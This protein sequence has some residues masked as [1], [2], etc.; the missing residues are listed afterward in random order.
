MT[1]SLCD[2][3]IWKDGKVARGII[4]RCG[5]LVGHG[6][7]HV[8]VE[9]LDEAGGDIPPTIDEEHSGPGK[10]DKCSAWDDWKPI[11]DISC[12][13][14]LSIIYQYPVRTEYPS[15]IGEHDWFG[16]Y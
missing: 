1:R 7:D 16:T 2:Q 3:P 10:R 6:G 5:L 11:R 8:P 4:G 14:E 9:V 12:E 13:A 15:G